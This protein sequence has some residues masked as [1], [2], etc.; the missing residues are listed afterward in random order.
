MAS[1]DADSASGRDDISSATVSI[2]PVPVEEAGEE[3]DSYGLPLGDR[4]HIQ[5]E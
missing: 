5:A 3:Y 4:P 1:R 2:T